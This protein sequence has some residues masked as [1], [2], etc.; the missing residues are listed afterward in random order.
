[1]VG[2]MSEKAT[3]RPLTLNA[4]YSA[5]MPV[6][7]MPARSPYQR[8]FR[9]FAG[10]AV[11][12]LLVIL[13]ISIWTPVSLSDDARKLIGWGAGAIVV[14]AV[15][16]AYRLG[17]KE[18]L[19][20]LKAGCRVELA[21]GKIIQRR[22]GVSVVEIPIDQI[23]SLRQSRGGWL[24]VQSSNPERQIAVP[25]E[26]VGFENLKRE[27]A[28]NRIVVPLTVKLSPW[29]FLP[30]APF[31]VACFFLLTSHNHAVVIISG[32]VS[33]L[34]EGFSVFSLRR[35]LKSNRRVP[36]LLLVYGLTFLILAW[37]VYARATSRL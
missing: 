35:T 24:F 11:G 31:V 22:P 12:L 10:I 16:V 36:L 3:I 27:L 9:I 37:I 5:T 8:P 6:Y 21:D 32:G 15:V 13:W 30:S 19:W 28:A 25:S 34:L 14:V 17:F 2:Q 7:E 1:L 20:K 29:L 33:L 18:G 23:E 4:L 26:I